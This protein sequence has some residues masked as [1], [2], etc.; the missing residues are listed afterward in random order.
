VLVIGAE[1]AAPSSLKQSKRR[2]RAAVQQL[3]RAGKVV[4]KLADKDKLPPSCADA[5]TAAITSALEHTNS[6]RTNLTAC[7]S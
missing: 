7:A 3:T 5:L 2:L 1:A 4:G 6:L